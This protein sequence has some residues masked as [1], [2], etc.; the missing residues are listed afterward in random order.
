MATDDP[1][2][3][4]Q[5]VAARGAPLWRRLIAMLYD[6]ALLIG[7]LVVAN[8]VYMLL[9][10]YPYELIFA[11]TFPSLD[12]LPRTF[13][14]IYLLAVILGFHV[15]PWTHG[16]QTLG[17]AAWRLRLVRDDGGP[18]PV[19][20]ALRRFGWA[21]LGL[22]PAGLGLWRCLRDPQRLAWYDRRS[23]TRVAVVGGDLAPAR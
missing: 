9:L 8:G 7:V 5:P 4:D 16:G 18:V 17:M 23:G 19:A 20:L 21:A 13:H 15:Y 6:L 2:T 10:I 14:Q 22:L 1:Q 3:P 11:R 12:L